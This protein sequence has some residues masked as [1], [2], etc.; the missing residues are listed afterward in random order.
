MSIDLF[1][2]LRAKRC[3]LIEKIST[4]FQTKE[5]LD[6]RIRIWRGAISDGSFGFEPEGRD[7]SLDYDDREWFRE[8][9]EVD[10]KNED[11]ELYERKPGFEMSD[12]KY[13]TNVCYLLDLNILHTILQ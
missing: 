5:S 4:L 8:A 13:L 12:W 7:I 3:N 11:E 9:V 1:V 6:N 2:S 10:K